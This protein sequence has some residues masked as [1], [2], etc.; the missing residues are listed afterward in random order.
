MPVDTYRTI[1]GDSFDAVAYRLW[2]DERLAARL[3]AANA[4]YADVLL[5]EAGVTLSIPSVERLPRRV[6][7]LPGWAV[8]EEA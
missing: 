3:I 7:A 4:D 2:G 8:A 1:Q 6:T 5:F